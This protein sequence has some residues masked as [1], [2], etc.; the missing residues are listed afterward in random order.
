MWWTITKSWNKK[1]MHS[2][3]KRVNFSSLDINLFTF[4]Q[5]YFGMQLQLAL[6]NLLLISWPRFDEA[7]QVKKKVATT[8]T[9]YYITI[10]FDYHHY[11]YHYYYHHCY[12]Y[13]YHYY[14]HHCYHCYYHYYYHHCYHYR[15]NTSTT[16]DYSVCFWEQY[17]MLRK[18]IGSLN[19]N[20][21]SHIQI[22]S[23]QNTC[24]N[25][26]CWIAMSGCK[27]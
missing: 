17:V 7:V 16:T 11:W 15:S 9:Y 19:C 12:H 8:P 27:V 6:F 3:I 2:R 22:S 21:L 25:K 10:N 4:C 23:N 13:Y 1:C 26:V 5:Y 24:S 18:K 14:Y 20:F